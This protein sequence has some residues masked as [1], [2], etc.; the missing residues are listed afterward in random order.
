MPT[1]LGSAGIE[2]RLTQT[3]PTVK[4]PI[5]IFFIDKSGTATNCAALDQQRRHVSATDFMY[6][7]C[8]AA[9]S[10]YV[11]FFLKHKGF[12]LPP[13]DLKSV[14]IHGHHHRL[15]CDSDGPRWCLKNVFVVSIVPLISLLIYVIS[16]NSSRRQSRSF[17]LSVD[18]QVRLVV[19][20][21]TL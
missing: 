5:L 18:D 7:R 12:Q 9:Y 13:I 11:I 10:F 1:R 3:F 6:A 20:G 19:A 17:W 15:P 2:A 14:P 8:Y 4:S 16:N 21:C